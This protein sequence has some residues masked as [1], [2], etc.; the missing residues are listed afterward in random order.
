MIVNK[1]EILKDVVV[2]RRSVGPGKMNG[3]QIPNATIEELIALA[4]WAPTHA[5]T[6]PWRFYIYTGDAL[7]Q[8][9]ADHAKLYWDNTAE[10]KRLEATAEKLRT[11]VDK[12][13][14]AVVAVMKRGQNDKIPVIEEI[15]AASAAIQNLLLGAAASGIAAL[16]STGGMILKPAMKEYLGL[17]EHDHVMGVLYLGYTDEP[18]KDGIRSV[19][20]EMKII[21]K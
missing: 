6:E 21:W 2:N 17:G 3:K 5:R 20:L 18:H 11:N 8:F 13:S 1:F 12:V 7:K 16:W 10:D 4:D 19:P 9:G 15:A 14:H